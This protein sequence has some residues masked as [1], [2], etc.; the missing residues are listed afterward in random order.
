[1]VAGTSIRRPTG[2]ANAGFHRSFDMQGHV[3]LLPVFRFCEFEARARGQ[4]ALDFVL[5][6]FLSAR[7]VLGMS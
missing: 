5:E 1:M 6:G 3:G 7:V 2:L 4:P